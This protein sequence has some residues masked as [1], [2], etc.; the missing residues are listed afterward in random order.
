[1]RMKSY[2]MVYP[3]NIYAYYF[4]YHK[5]PAFNGRFLFLQG[6]YKKQ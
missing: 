5:T 1:M 6:K 3:I 2:Y 4:Y